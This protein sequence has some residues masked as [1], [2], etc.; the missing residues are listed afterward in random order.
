MKPYPT[1]SPKHSPKHLL[2]A[3]VTSALWAAAPAAQSHVT[4]EQAVATAG[5]SYRAVFKVGHGCDGL[6]TTGIRVQLPAGVQGAKPM[7]K[8]GWALTM[9]TDK[10]ATPYTRH[11]KEITGDVSEVGWTATSKEAALPDAHYDEF[12]LRAN[13]PSTAGALWF[14]VVQSC[15]DKNGKQVTKEW[16][17]MPSEGHST[18]GLQTPA[19]LL[20]LEPAAPSGS[21]PHH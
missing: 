17:Q 14:K 18:R 10:L 16:T 21:A 4:L 1:H 13:L 2:S 20:L 19:A 6:A 3:L 8:A 5:S 15:E 9:R 11:G 12:I 7:P